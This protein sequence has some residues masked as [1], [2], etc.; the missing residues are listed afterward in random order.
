MAEW[1]GVLALQA[2]D[3]SVTPQHPHRKPGIAA[4]VCHCSIRAV[5]RSQTLPR[6]V[7][8]QESWLG[9]DR[10]RHLM[11]ATPVPMYA[12]TDTHILHHYGGNLN[13]TDL[14]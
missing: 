5:E 3:L 6:Q 9:C 8:Y 14:S 4:H 12:A 1:I 11:C 13:K 10:G 2:R 7:L